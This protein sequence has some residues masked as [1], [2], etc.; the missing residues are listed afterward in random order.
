MTKKRAREEFAD[1]AFAM[2]CAGIPLE[3]AKLLLEAQYQIEAEDTEGE[4]VQ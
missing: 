3:D 2:A 1:A 4:V